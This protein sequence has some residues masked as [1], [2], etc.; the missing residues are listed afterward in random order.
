MKNQK[1]LT[2]EYFWEQKREEIISKFRPILIIAFIILS[3]YVVGSL[4]VPEDSCF[5]YDTLVCSAIETFLITFIMG[6]LLIILILTVLFCTYYIII[7][8][9][10]DWI[11]SNWKKAK[12]RAEDE[13]R[14]RKRK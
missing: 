12:R 6:F 1:Q 14:W 11:K 4:V 2:W 5:E 7:N 8:A 13:V 9:F 3:S 10:I